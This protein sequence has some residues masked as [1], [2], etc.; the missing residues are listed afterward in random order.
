MLNF[1]SQ[2]SRLR[3]ALLISAVLCLPLAARAAP[4]KCADDTKLDIIMRD[5]GKK[6][7]SMKEIDFA[8]RQHLPGPKGGW[9]CPLK[10]GT[11][12]CHACDGDV[13]ILKDIKTDD[14]HFLVLPR[15][16]KSGI[17]DASLATGRAGL[18]YLNAAWKHRKLIST[19]KKPVDDEHVVLVVNPCS[20]RGQDWLHIHLARLNPDP[21]NWTDRCTQASAAGGWKDAAF[22]GYSMIYLKEDKGGIADDPF[23]LLEKKAGATEPGH[24][25][26]AVVHC[27]LGGFLLLSDADTFPEGDFIDGTH[28]KGHNPPCGCDQRTEPLA[29]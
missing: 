12:D 27:A 9:S 28:F 7:P 15:S 10:S 17:E 14:D 6:C 4:G 16:Y 8:K 2:P 5:V 13:V 23:E 1:Q 18:G 3:D 26:L 19:A 25:G 22:N 29:P 20:K 11:N 24:Q 21:P